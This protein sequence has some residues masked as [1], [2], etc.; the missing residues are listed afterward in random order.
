MFEESECNLRKKSKVLVL[1]I[2]LVFLFLVT[3]MPPI[4]PGM[5]PPG[6][7]PGQMHGPHPGQMPGQGPGGPMRMP[8]LTAMRPPMMAPPPQMSQG[9]SNDD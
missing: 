6:M 9:A 7:R 1:L 4:M 2:R 5:M 3:G 8:H